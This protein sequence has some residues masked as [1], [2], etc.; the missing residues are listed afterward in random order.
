MS[1][2]D[3]LVGRAFQLTQLGTDFGGALQAWMQA[4][5]HPERPQRPEAIAEVQLNAAVC[6]CHLGN[7]GQ[8]MDLCSEALELQQSVFADWS[9]DVQRTFAIYV[10]AAVAAGDFAQAL[11]VSD[12]A[13]AALAENPEECEPYTFTMAG[14]KRAALALEMGE[15][16][17]AED[18]L[19]FALDQLELFFE[20][21]EPAEELVAEVWLQKAKALEVRAQNRLLGG[22]GQLGEV[23]VL[24]ALR[25]LG[26]AGVTEGEFFERLHGMSSTL[27]GIDDL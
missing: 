25:C 22:A 15:P 1:S 10:D 26:E 12:M 20:M 4:L 5:E 18:A 2:Y 17:A 3:D 8:A 19:Q 27:A 16:D 9:D 13:M 7:F 11:E 14:Q 21:E 6:C 24:E 23:D